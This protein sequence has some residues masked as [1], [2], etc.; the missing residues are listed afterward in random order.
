V[1]DNTGDG[2][3]YDQTLAPGV[4]V[5]AEVTCDTMDNPF[6]NLITAAA[7]SSPSGDLDVFTDG[8]VSLPSTCN[9]I[10]PAEVMIAK[11]CTEIR[12][13]TMGNDLVVEV[14]GEIVVTNSGNDLLQ[15]VMVTDT[16]EGVTETVFTGSLNPGETKTFPFLDTPDIP[17]QP[18]KKV[19][20]TAE[21]F[22]EINADCPGAETC[23]P[24]TDKFDPVTATFND[25]ARVT[26]TGALS[27]TGVD[28]GATADNCDLCPTP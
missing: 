7:K 11:Q 23:D 12:L 25:S 10:P 16:Y 19:C 22:C 4:S 27:N 8:Q 3:S 2:G 14:L 17:N 13:M 15:N 26:G 1:P 20:S 9:I 18:A 5:V 6:N 21:T 24:T 28:V